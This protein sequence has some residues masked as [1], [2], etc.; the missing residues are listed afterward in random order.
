MGWGSGEDEESG[1]ILKVNKPWGFLFWEEFWIADG[2]LVGKFDVFTLTLALSLVG[3][4]DIAGDGLLILVLL[5]LSVA[6]FWPL[7][8]LFTFMLKRSIS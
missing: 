8:L 1:A 5:L 6:L 3:R 4:G 2:K 7:G